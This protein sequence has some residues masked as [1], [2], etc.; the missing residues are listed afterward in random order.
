MDQDVVCFPMQASM[1]GGCFTV[2][3]GVNDCFF[4]VSMSSCHI[5]QSASLDREGFVTK[6][7]LVKE[8]R[9]DQS[10]LGQCG[11]FRGNA[12]L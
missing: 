5:C 7:K 6:L 2:F 11:D 10:F 4:K 9:R 12:D 1:A 8:R 3:L